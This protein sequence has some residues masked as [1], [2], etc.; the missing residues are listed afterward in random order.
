MTPLI[1]NKIIIVQTKQK[2]L[3]CFPVDEMQYEDTQ[4]RRN[5][6]SYCDRCESRQGSIEIIITGS[7]NKNDA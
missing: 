1:L 7:T 5:I 6:F 2:K 4:K 3:R